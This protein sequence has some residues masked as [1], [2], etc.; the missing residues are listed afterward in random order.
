MQIM[1]PTK[2]YR[3]AAEAANP[4]DQYP[5]LAQPFLAG[6]FICG[7]HGDAPGATYMRAARVDTDVEMYLPPLPS[8]IASDAVI[9][10]EYGAGLMCIMGLLGEGVTPFPVQPVALPAADILTRPYARRHKVKSGFTTIPGHGRRFDPNVTASV[11]DGMAH[12]EA[13]YGPVVIWH[14]AERCTAVAPLSGG[15]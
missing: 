9:L 14:D 10:T 7:A 12:Y 13:G 8:A 1:T 15:A 5:Q 2:L 3:W 11:A 6:G 4:C